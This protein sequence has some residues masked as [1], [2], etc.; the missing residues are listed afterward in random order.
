M[1]G[2]NETALVQADRVRVRVRVSREVLEARVD[3]GA[4][5]AGADRVRVSRELLE[6]RVDGGA[7]VAGAD[8]VRVSRELLEGR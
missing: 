3:G 1:S 2:T 4:A 5:V 8:R 6:A 7:A